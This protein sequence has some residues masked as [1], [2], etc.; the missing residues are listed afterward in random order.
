MERTRTLARWSAALW[1]A[2]LI[3]AVDTGTAQADCVQ[4]LALCA[5]DCD[6]RTKPE[7]PERP[8]CARSCV[9]SYQRCERIEIFQSTTGGGVLNRGKTLAP[10]Q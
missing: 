6:Q 4:G 3:S 7:R 10:A 2:L 9:S 5:V 1:L 8:Q